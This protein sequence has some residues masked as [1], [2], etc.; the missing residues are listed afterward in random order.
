MLNNKVCGA[1]NARLSANGGGVFKG[2]KFK[3]GIRESPGVEGAVRL[4]VKTLNRYIGDVTCCDSQSAEWEGGT[5]ANG[6]RGIAPLNAAR[7]AQ[8]ASPTTKNNVK[9][10]RSGPIKPVYIDVRGE[11][12]KMI[13]H[14]PVMKFA[15]LTSRFPRRQ[16]ALN[17]H[18]LRFPAEQ[19]L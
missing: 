3:A 12:A 19:H 5:N 9:M 14:K 17:P 6:R 11:P 1:K 2:Q 15:R 8:R 4:I 13:Q 16:G 18:S 7:T 10:H